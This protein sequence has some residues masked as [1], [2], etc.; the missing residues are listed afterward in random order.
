MNWKGRRNGHTGEGT[1]PETRKG[2]RLGAYKTRQVGVGRDWFL[3]L[4][5]PGSSVHVWMIVRVSGPGPT[6][7]KVPPG[8]GTELRR[9]FLLRF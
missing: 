5:G 3:H 7:E 6:D 4:F 2:Q 1:I 9:L 8:Q